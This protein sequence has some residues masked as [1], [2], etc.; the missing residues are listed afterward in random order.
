LL[1]FLSSSRRYLEKWLNLYTLFCKV[2]HFF[3]PLLIT[4]VSRLLCPWQKH[5]KMFPC[6]CHQTTPTL[7]AW[8][9]SMKTRL[10]TP[11]LVVIL[12]STFA[13]TAVFGQTTFTWIGAGDRTS[14]TDGNNWNPNGLPT[15][16]TQDTAQWD[17][18]TTSNLVINYGSTSLPGTGFG[19]SGI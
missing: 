14:L 11:Q 17:G 9:T 15:G 18:V 16:A 5:T 1:I 8:A 6:Q 19:T 3:H 7:S 4:P 12:C 13:T 10:I 2:L